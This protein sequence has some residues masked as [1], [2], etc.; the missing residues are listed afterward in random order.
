MSLW[1]QMSAPLNL[2]RPQ[3]LDLIFR[4]WKPGEAEECWAVCHRDG[5]DITCRLRLCVYSM[6]LYWR[7]LNKNVLRFWYHDRETTF[8]QIFIQDSWVIWI[9]L[10]LRGCRLF[11]YLHILLP[12]CTISVFFSTFCH[13][14]CLFQVKSL[15][16]QSFNSFNLLRNLYCYRLCVVKLLSPG[17]QVFF[18]C[19]FTVE[20]FYSSLVIFRIKLSQ[21]CIH[22]FYCTVIF[23][24]N[25]F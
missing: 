22:I 13:V 23:K 3:C 9:R 16:L 8:W 2:W 1:K 20:Q 14:L 5:A 19:G 24:I 4:W 12:Y 17:C 11:V 7:P 18:F 25:V 10:G 15:H 6:C 21:T